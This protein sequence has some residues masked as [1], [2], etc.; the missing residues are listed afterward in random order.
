MYLSIKIIDNR[1]QIVTSFVIFMV[2][3]LE[4][5]EFNTKT[6]FARPDP[7]FREG[8]SGLPHIVQ[9]SKRNFINYVTLHKL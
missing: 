7:L 1:V 9:F 6:F 3:I 5:S 4:E 2:Y 8:G